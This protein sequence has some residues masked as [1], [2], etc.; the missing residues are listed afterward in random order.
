LD[1]KGD[2]PIL[3]HLFLASSSLEIEQLLG[4]CHAKILAG[5]HGGHLK[6]SPKGTGND[7]CES[8]EITGK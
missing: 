8:W 7:G 6:L 1:W 5:N 2:G 3:E 4:S